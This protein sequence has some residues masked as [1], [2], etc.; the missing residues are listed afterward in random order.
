MKSVLY[1]FFTAC[2]HAIH[3]QRDT[4]LAIPSVSLSACL[5]TAGV[6]STGVHISSRLTLWCGFYSSSSMK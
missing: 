3:A 1:D 5:S 4:A 2:Q 6:V